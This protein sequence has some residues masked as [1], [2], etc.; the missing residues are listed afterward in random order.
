MKQSPHSRR[1]RQGLI[2][3]PPSQDYGAVL[4]LQRELCR[5]RV[6]EHRP[7]TLLVIEH[8]PVFT[9]GRRSKPEH[10]GRD[11][12]SLTQMGYEVCEV[13]RGGS[14]TYHGP[15]QIVGYPILLL[16]DFCPGPKAYVHM[17]EEVVIRVL[18]EWGIQARRVEK[19]PGVWV[20]HDASPLTPTLSPAVGEGKR[21][22]LPLMSSPPLGGEVKV[23]GI[24]FLGTCEKLPRSEF[25]LLVE[26]HCTGLP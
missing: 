11:G 8:Q 1:C 20:Q 17:L 7:D 5:E 23:R 6:E 24:F 21:E 16:R 4:E 12:V 15:G 19:V 13:D 18:K 3:F 9:V 22:E 10:C 26:S 25:A 2:H 14:V